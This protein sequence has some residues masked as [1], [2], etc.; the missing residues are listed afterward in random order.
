[1][2][3]STEF[4]LEAKEKLIFYLNTHT[5]P[6]GL[7]TE[8]AACSIAAIN[9]AISGELTDTIPECMS[10][11]IG[12][13]IINIQDAI[14]TELRNSTEWKFLLPQAA[15]TG[16]E[17]EQERKEIIMNWM[18]TIVLPIIQ[19]IADKKGFGTKWKQMCELKTIAAAAA[20]AAA[21][22]AAAA[23]AAAADAAASY[24]ADA[25]AAAD[26]AD[27]AASYAASDAASD[28]ATAATASYAAAAAAASDAAA[29]TA[30][31]S[32]WK[33]VNPCLLLKQLIEV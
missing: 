32:Y 28:A 6:K 17:K 15:G 25:A 27:A 14:P 19:P 26:A 10:K 12:K 18:W 21:A 13:W 1:M 31:A 23:A 20:A 9:L 4:T 29:A 22:D 30:A 7:G 33:T 24:A 16:R 2:S 5:L 8:E 11:V 3:N